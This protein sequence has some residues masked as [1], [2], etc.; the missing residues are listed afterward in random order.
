MLSKLLQLF[1]HLRAVQNALQISYMHKEKKTTYW[2]N[3]FSY[4]HWNNRMTN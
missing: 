1:P 4:L 2:R 3:K